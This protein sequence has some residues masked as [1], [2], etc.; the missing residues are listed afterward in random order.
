MRPAVVVFGGVL[1]VL[2]SLL[3]G[4]ESRLRWESAARARQ[5]EAVAD[6]VERCNL[7]MILDT[8]RVTNTPAAATSVERLF[9]A[10]VG[11]VDR[12]AFVALRSY[13]DA[14]CK[15]VGSQCALHWQGPSCR[16]ARG[17][18]ASAAR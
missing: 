6:L 12:A 7:Q 1:A 17:L 3:A 8:C 16:A 5:T 14:M 13:G 2:V 11:E 4:L 10:G 9:I 15:E 18:Y